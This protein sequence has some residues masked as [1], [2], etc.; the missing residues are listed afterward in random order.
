MENTTKLNQIPVRQQHLHIE[1]DFLAKK[2]F[3]ER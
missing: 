3:P 2:S 1:A